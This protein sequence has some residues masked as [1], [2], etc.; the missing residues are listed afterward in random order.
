[1]HD[2]R[3]RIKITAAQ[4]SGL[5][6]LQLARLL[7]AL[8]GVR[9]DLTVLTSAVV[10][11]IVLVQGPIGTAHTVAQRLGLRNRF[12]LARLLEGQGLPSLHGLAEWITVLS[13]VLTSERKNVSLCWMAFRSHR[14]PSACYRMVKR[15]TGRR[16]ED[17]RSRGSAWLM[18]EFLKHVRTY[19]RRRRQRLAHRIIV[20][21]HAPVRYAAPP[22]AS[23]APRTAH[24]RPYTAAS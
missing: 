3:A 19:A 20:S 17:V 18:Q 11:A 4:I 24:T 9:P 12:E 10:D 8:H 6:V 13:W 22:F 5:R 23:R 15:V 1:M 14:H 16:W 2:R 7:T 21:S